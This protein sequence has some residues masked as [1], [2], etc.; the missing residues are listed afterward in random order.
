IPQSSIGHIFEKFYRVPTGERH[1]V[2]GFGLGL[3]YVKLIV[4]KHG[5]T[6]SVRS[7]IGKGTAFT[8]KLP[9]DGR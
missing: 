2:K 1:D 6:I 8:I 4:G 3:Y 5:G 9:Y 7:R